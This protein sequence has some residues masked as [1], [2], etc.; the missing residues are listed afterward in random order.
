MDMEPKEWMKKKE[1]NLQN[2]NLKKLW[3][4][5]LLCEQK[6]LSALS[7]SEAYDYMVSKL[8][9]CERKEVNSCRE[10]GVRIQRGDI[11]FVDYG[12]AYLCEI[13]YLHFGLILSMKH[14]KAFVV[15]VSGNYRAYCQAYAK[16]NPTG[17]SHLMRLGWIKGLNK[18]SVLYVNDAKWINTARVIDVKAHIDVHGDLFRQIRERTK[19]MI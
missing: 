5:S 7:P 6:M 18:V 11:C 3:Q 16:E 10:L 9:Y 4:E 17:R 8:N 13:G 15:P 14:G 19:E 1:R 2:N 12:S